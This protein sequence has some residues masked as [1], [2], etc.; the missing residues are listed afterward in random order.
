MTFSGTAYPTLHLVEVTGATSSSALDVNVTGTV[1]I[2][3]GSSGG[4]ASGTLAQAAEV[5]LA[6]AEI[7]DGS[8]GSYTSSNTTVLSQEP[9]VSTYWTSAV[10]KVVTSSTG[11]VTPTWARTG[12]SSNTFGFRVISFKE[13][14][15]SGYSVT[16]D[17][18]SYTVTG[19]TANLLASHNPITAVQGSYA[20][21]GQTVNFTYGV[22]GGYTITADQGAYTVVGSNALVDVS[23]NAAQGSYTLTGQVVNFI[24]VGLTNR[25]I[26]ADQGSYSL[27]GQTVNVLYNKKTFADFGS[28]TLTGRSVGL[29]WSGA[30]QSSGY[31]CHKMSISSMG[32]GL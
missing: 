4:I 13:A 14:T 31:N 15:G 6:L 9:A 25:N 20:L 1:A 30:P 8:D 16:A 32:I 22:V 2:S 27:N 23:M 5:I 18:G 24:Y 29:Y 17:Q 10:S 7:N 28:Y 3:G 11:S 26:V 19:Q 12:N 21:T